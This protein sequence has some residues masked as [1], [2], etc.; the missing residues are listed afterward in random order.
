MRKGCSFAEICSEQLITLIFFSYFFF[1]SSNAWKFCS[2]AYR[3]AL[4]IQCKYFMAR[5]S[6]CTKHGDKMLTICCMEEMTIAGEQPGEQYNFA[7]QF[8]V[9]LDGKY[10]QI[11]LKLCI[12]WYTCNRHYTL[13]CLKYT[14]DTPSIPNLGSC[15]D[16]LCR[17]SN[18]K[19]A[20]F[21]DKTFH[22]N[23]CLFI[24]VYFILV[25]EK[26]QSC[27]GCKDVSY[28]SNECQ[29]KLLSSVNFVKDKVKQGCG[30]TGWNKMGPQASCPQNLV[31]AQ[32][33]L[34]QR[35]PDGP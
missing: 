24:F 29:V 5:L 23:V 10:C 22:Q 18:I 1:C 3:L 26:L 2:L 14:I 6:H 19:W 27:G 25:R 33:M 13:P 4:S 35:S 17:G 11:R 20:L 34:R 31:R 7:Q 12:T 32:K 16:K 8:L 30:Q 15:L 21:F 28:C 9:G